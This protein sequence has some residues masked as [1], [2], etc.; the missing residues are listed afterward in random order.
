MYRFLGDVHVH[1]CFSFNVAS[2]ERV[3][4]DILICGFNPDATY[5]GKSVRFIFQVATTIKRSSS[6]HPF[7]FRSIR[8]RRLRRRPKIRRSLARSLARARRHLFVATTPRRSLPHL[9]MMLLLLPSNL[10]E[11]APCPGLTSI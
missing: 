7:N 8:S 10:L 9:Q 6:N 4:K 1:T 5:V 11:M 2:I 3:C